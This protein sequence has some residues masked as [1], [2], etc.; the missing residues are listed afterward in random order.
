MAAPAIAGFVVFR[1]VVDGQRGDITAAEAY[2][3]RRE[4]ADADGGRAVFAMGWVGDGR[5]E[6][7]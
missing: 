6:F 4:L 3:H 7:V 1:D 2:R 5:G